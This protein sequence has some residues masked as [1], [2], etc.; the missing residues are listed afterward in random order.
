MKKFLAAIALLV[1]TAIASIQSARAG[2]PTVAHITLDGIVNPIKA[3]YIV[4]SLD[5]ARSEG[6]TVVLLSID[7]PGGLV[8]SMQEIVGAIT[9][10]KVPVVG[11]VEPKSAQATSAGAL[12]LMAVSY[13]HLRAHETPEH[14]V[15]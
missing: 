1:L 9:N 3:R 2:G 15:C 14:L 11:L 8:S 10:S 13:T 12:I 4:Q 7:T 5:R 6:A